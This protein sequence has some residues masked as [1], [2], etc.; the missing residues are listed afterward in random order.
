[1]LKKSYYTEECYED[2]KSFS[3]GREFGSG[4]GRFSRRDFGAVHLKPS[5]GGDAGRGAKVYSERS[6]VAELPLVF[7]RMGCVVWH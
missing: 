7:C 5:L 1:M 4:L 3:V 6:V 2:A